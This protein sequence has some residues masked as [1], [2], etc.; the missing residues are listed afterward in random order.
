MGSGDGEAALFGN[1]RSIEI[2]CNIN[3]ELSLRLTLL[4]IAVIL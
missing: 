1:T 2:F 3:I 4:S